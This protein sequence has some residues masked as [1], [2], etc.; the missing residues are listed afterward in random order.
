MYLLFIKA[1]ERHL[2]GSN[3]GRI[4][5]FLL[6]LAGQWI[7][8]F[9]AFLHDLLLFHLLLQLLC[10]FGQQSLLVRAGLDHGQSLLRDELLALVGGGLEDGGSA[11]Q[12]DEGMA[13]SS[14]EP[15]LQVSVL[16]TDDVVI[17]LQHG[18]EAMCTGDG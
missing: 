17:A 18:L 1:G 4:L 12:V 16:G 2:F 13:S 10:H 11:V 14:T 9:G 6:L 3:L 15:L 5:R 8:S 7:G